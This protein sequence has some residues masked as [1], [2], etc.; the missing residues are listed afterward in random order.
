VLPETY[1][2]NSTGTELYQNN[3]APDWL[4]EAIAGPAATK[5]N[6]TRKKV[7]LTL[8]M[9]RES[10]REPSSLRTSKARETLLKPYQ[11]QADRTIVEFEIAELLD[12]DLWPLT[13][14]PTSNAI[15]TRNKK[16]Y[17]QISARSVNAEGKALAPPPIGPNQLLVV[18]FWATW[19]APCITEGERLVAAFAKRAPNEIIWWT[20]DAT[21]GGFFMPPRQ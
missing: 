2:F 13:P 8:K 21:D 18:Q 12:A 11:D 7:K 1:V 5:S 14:P 17:T 6:E 15:L 10:K 20:I 19:C 16:T 4:R 3:L 9:L